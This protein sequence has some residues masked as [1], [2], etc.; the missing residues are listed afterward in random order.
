MS[1]RPIYDAG[2]LAQ[3]SD[4]LRNEV[5]IPT[6]A[7]GYMTT[8]DQLNTLLAGGRADLCIMNPPNLL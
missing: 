4:V 8:S 7:T 5:R 1:A 6:V 2:A 3:Y